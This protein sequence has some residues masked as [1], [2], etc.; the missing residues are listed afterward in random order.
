VTAEVQGAVAEIRSAFPESAVVAEEDGQGGA[1]I[2]VESVDIGQKYAPSK[3]WF[4]FHITFQY[5]RADVYPHHMGADVKRV[6]GVG[7]GQGVSA[8]KWRDSPSL[9]ISR[10]SNRLEP[11]VDTA[12]TKLM[13]V[14][15]WLKNF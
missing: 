1:F 14:I 5:P 8:Q 10:R 12:A 3:T 11:T 2:R 6:D 13:K 4:G 15:A 9:Q 7:F